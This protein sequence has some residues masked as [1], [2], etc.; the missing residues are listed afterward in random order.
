MALLIIVNIK[1]T[2][3]SIVDVAIRPEYYL[4]KI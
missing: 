2:P 1:H 4:L 3:L